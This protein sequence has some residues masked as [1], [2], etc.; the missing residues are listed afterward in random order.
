MSKLSAKHIILGCLGLLVAVL[1]CASLIVPAPFFRAPT[2]LKWSCISNLKQIDA[3]IQLWAYENK[4]EQT[5]APDFPAA[6]KYLKN[7][8]MPLCPAGGSYDPGKT[9][10]DAPTCS[11]G[12]ELGHSLP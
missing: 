1:V 9:I 10:A 4:K 6:I 2:P 8:L 7:G 5:E 3:A 12:V 11:K